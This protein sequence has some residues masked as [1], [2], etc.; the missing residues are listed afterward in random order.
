MRGEKVESLKRLC[1]LA[2]EKKSVMVIFC[3]NKVFGL[4]W[5]LMPAAFVQN[6]QGRLIQRFIDNGM[7]VYEKAGGLK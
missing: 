7:Y 5:R 6:M 4:D 2:N 1:E 3:N